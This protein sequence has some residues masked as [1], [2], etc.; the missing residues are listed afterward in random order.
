MYTLHTKPSA[1]VLGP[2]GEAGEG[3]VGVKSGGQ[4]VRIFPEALQVL[5]RIAA[6]EFEGVTFGL[7]SS[8][9]EPR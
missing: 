3:V 2:L 4:T 8:S 7:A 9:E 5:Q 6:G 1:P